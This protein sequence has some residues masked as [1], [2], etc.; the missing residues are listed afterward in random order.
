H[1]FGLWEEA[2]VPRENP[3][4]HGENMQTPHRKC[5]P[6]TFLLQASPGSGTA[7]REPLMYLWSRF[8]ASMLLRE[9]I[10]SVCY[11]ACPTCTSPNLNPTAPTLADLDYLALTFCLFDPEN[12]VLPKVRR[13]I[14]RSKT[15]PGPVAEDISDFYVNR[16]YENSGFQSEMKKDDQSLMAA[17]SENVLTVNMLL[18]VFFLPGIVGGC[19]N[20][21]LFADTPGQIEALSGSCLQIPCRYNSTDPSYNVTRPIYG[22]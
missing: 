2:G 19:P 5:E 4:M 16:F 22:V 1:I 8:R 20:S 11:P 6:R 3:R 18:I 13:F 14:N 10:I 17:L 7:Q 21:F 9:E 12:L 15:T